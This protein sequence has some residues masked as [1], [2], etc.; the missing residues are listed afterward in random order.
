MNGFEI[1]ININ[2]KE[3]YVVFFLKRRKVSIEV[4]NCIYLPVKEPE[5][6]ALKR[7]LKQIVLI[8]LQVT[9]HSHINRI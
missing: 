1:H 6:I 2:F 7:K 3:N 9:H 4:G 8:I 5:K